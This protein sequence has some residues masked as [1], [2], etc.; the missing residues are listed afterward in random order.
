MLVFPGTRSLN[1]FSSHYS[2]YI[3]PLWPHPF[4]LHVYGPTPMVQARTF[5]LSPTPIHPTSRCPTDTPHLIHPRKLTTF[6]HKFCSFSCI[7]HLAKRLHQT[8]HHSSQKSGNYPR[9]LFFLH[10]PPLP[11]YQFVP[12]AVPSKYLQSRTSPFHKYYYWPPCFHSLP[13]SPPS[14]L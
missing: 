1:F 13:I 6:S 8:P 9:L 7:S 2:T 4:N 5:P 12:P 3:L 10:P 14:T 11:I